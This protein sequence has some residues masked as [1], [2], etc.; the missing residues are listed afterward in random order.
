MTRDKQRLLDYLEHMLEAIERIE[1]YTQGLDRRAFLRN[2]LVQDA[3]IRN[4]EVIG[5]ASRNIEKHYPQFAA[6]HPQL[7]LAS[8]Y[9]MR[10][11]LSHGYFNPDCSL[12]R[13]MMA[14]RVARQFGC[15]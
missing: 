4:L 13:G 14:R 9:Q 6:Q 10:N 8:A 1:H 5:E 12:G 2:R 11:A 15:G 3:V 7:P